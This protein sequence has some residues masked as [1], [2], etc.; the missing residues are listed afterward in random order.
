MPAG[1]IA[2]VGAAYVAANGFLVPGFSV[3][4]INIIVTDAAGTGVQSITKVSTDKGNKLLD[5]WFYHMALW[6]DMNNDGLLVRTMRQ[7]T[8]PGVGGCVRACP[9]HLCPVC[10]TL[11]RVLR[12]CRRTS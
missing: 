5:G 10:R 2:G 6:H 7:C 12:G 4:G 11:R 3:G 1:A 8:M 9:A